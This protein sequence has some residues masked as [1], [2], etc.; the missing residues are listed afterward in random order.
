MI[1]CRNNN[2]QIV[3]K[4][5]KSQIGGES[6]LVSLCKW[7]Y[8]GH[9]Q[10]TFK[11]TENWYKWTLPNEPLFI[12]LAWM[13]CSQVSISTL[14]VGE[15]ALCVIVWKLSRWVS[16]P[17]YRTQLDHRKKCRLG[18]FL[19]L[20]LFPCRRT[21]A[22]HQ[23]EAL[24]PLWCTCG[25]VWLAPRRCCTVYRF[26]D[27]NVRNGSRKTSLSWR[28]PS[29]SLVEFLADSAGAFWAGTCPMHWPYRGTL[30]L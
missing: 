16:A 8:S 9:P 3:K 2:M 23:A 5:K 20:P 30:V 21:S 11:E 22:H 13:G 7:K 10:H 14:L 29:A 15:L 1:T 26:P 6:S 25:K 24:E 18:A 28:M 17:L 4:K 12:K 19:T 27:P